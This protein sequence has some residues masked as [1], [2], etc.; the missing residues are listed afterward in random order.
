VASVVQ[1]ERFAK[2][3]AMVPTPEDEIV[4][5]D[6]KGFVHDLSEMMGSIVKIEE[7]TKGEAKEGADD[8]EAAKGKAMIALVREIF[9]AL[10]T[11]IS[12]SPAAKRRIGSRSS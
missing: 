5:F 11:A 10:D 12:A 8:E 4:F 7:G 2:A 6:L 3:L 9:A 1:H